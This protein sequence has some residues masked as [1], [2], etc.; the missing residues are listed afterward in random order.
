MTKADVTSIVWLVGAAAWMI[1]A[2]IVVVPPLDPAPRRPPPLGV[3]VG[4]AGAVAVAALVGVV[5]WFAVPAHVTAPVLLHVVLHPVVAIA[6]ATVAL[7]VIVVAL[8]L[9]AVGGVAG[10][11][12]AAIMD[13]V[14]VILML[15][16]TKPLMV[17]QLVISLAEGMEVVVD[18]TACLWLMVTACALGPIP[19]KQRIEMFGRDCVPPNLVQLWV[20]WIELLGPTRSTAALTSSTSALSCSVI[21]IDGASASVNAVMFL[22]A[23]SFPARLLRCWAQELLRIDIFVLVNALIAL[24]M[25]LSM[26]SCS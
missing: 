8:V 7:A 9:L 25:L 6:G 4:V 14:A 26:S 3:V 22:F 21:V 12:A 18:A 11:A 13:A 17:L 24:S 23:L 19:I 1:G 16:L 20:L 5:A 10:I 15:R 2:A